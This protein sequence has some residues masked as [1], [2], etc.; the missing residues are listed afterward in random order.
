M[1]K[2]YAMKRVRRSKSKAGGP[3]Y[4]GDRAG[5]KRAGF[6]FRSSSST[7]EEMKD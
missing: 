4:V 7:P 1:R 2:P 3:A 5:E 6:S